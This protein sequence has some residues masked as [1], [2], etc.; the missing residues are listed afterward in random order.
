MIAAA[1][2]SD[3]WRSQFAGFPVGINPRIV[4]NQTAPEDAA[5]QFSVAIREHIAAFCFGLV[6]HCFFAASALAHSRNGLP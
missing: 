4:P 3:N 5:P 1:L 2:A 6:D